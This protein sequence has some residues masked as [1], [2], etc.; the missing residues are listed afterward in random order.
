MV[1]KSR[2]LVY[3]KNQ[4]K[5][6]VLLTVILVLVI[7]LILLIGAYFF[8]LNIPGNPVNLKPVISGG[9][10]QVLNLSSEVKQFYPN[11]K[12]NHNEISYKIDASCTEEKKNNIIGAFD[13][14]SKKV[15]LIRFVLSENPDIDV[16]CTEDEKNAI[17]ENYFIA[18]EGGAKEI[19]QTERFNVITQGIILLYGNPHKAVKCDWP[20]VELHELIHV[21]GF[22][23][24]SD[25]NSLM[26]PYLTS[27]NQRLDQ[28]IVDNLKELYS[29]P[30]LPDLY[31]DNVNAI[32]KGRYLD[33]NVTIKNSGDISAENVLLTL[34]DENEKVDSFN[35]KKIDFGAGVTF[36][37]SNLKLI[38]RNSGDIKLVIDYDN[39]ISEIDESNN[40][41]ELNFE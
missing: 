12:F 16:S 31:F 14:L 17:K 34:L 15:G 37:V 29:I 11:M 9:E 25:K 41:A 2:N 38:N 20:N 33:F 36:S 24:S 35:L 6:Q 5:A 26:Y 28:S 19:I 22:D 30:N 1:N 4:E 13:E 18:G 7:I 8:Y 40:V 21:F 27:C 32:K 39:S 10:L 23:H 3:N